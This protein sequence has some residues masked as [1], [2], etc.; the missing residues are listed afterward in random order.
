MEFKTFLKT[1]SFLHL[2]LV[3]GLSIFTIIAVTQGKGFNTSTNGSDTLLYLVPIVALL[4]Y[5]GSKFM[6]K[7]S[8]SKLK[9]TDS[10]E[11]KLK[12]FQSASHIKY[13]LIEAPALFCLFVYYISGNALPLVIAICLLAFLFVQKPSKDRVLSQLPL[14]REEKNR[15]NF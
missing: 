6:F 7:K 13:L 10:L 8:M 5:F 1:L 12:R 15:L 11:D 14:S 3:I 4:G 2:S 9:E